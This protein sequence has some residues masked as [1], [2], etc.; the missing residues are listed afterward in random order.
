MFITAEEGF[1]QLD[2]MQKTLKYVFQTL[3][4]EVKLSLT[5]S[6][7]RSQSDNMGRRSLFTFNFFYELMKMMHRR[8]LDKACFIA[9][10]F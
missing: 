7:F 8:L 3:F 6:Q 5:N 9:V 1:S 4:R 10:Y 2:A